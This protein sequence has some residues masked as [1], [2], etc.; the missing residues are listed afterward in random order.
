[1]LEQIEDKADHQMHYYSGSA[2]Y[3]ST[4]HIPKQIG[5][6]QPDHGAPFVEKTQTKLKGGSFEARKSCEAQNCIR[7][8]D[9]IERMWH[10]P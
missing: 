10:Q 9:R 2:P 5:S 3:N 4:E 6:Q 1:M 7:E 8:L